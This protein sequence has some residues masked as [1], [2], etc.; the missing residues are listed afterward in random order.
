[1]L[2]LKPPFRAMDM[3]GLYKKI[4]SGKYSPI[5]SRYSRELSII[6]T[7][8]LQQNPKYR[9]SCNELLAHPIIQ[10]HV[11]EQTQ[12]IKAPKDRAQLLKT[13]KVP[14]DLNV[15]NHLCYSQIPLS[16]V[17]RH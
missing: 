16:Y 2:T 6:V 17:Y 12:C 3:G 10:K 1:M 9:P 5:P 15:R 13:I 14:F 11:M 8:M 4:M 7:S